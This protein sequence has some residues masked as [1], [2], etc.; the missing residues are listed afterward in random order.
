MNNT[1]N[2]SSINQ[3]LFQGALG[4]FEKRLRDAGIKEESIA[5]I[6]GRL[7][8]TTSEELVED[9]KTLL[10]ESEMTELEKMPDI[11]A[12]NKKIDSIL[13]DKK[14]ISL[15]KYQEEKLEKFVADFE[16]KSNSSQSPK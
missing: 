16:S 13:Q 6:C 7:I 15:E 12:R 10:S 9:L 3:L 2:I 5:F 8:R 1:I 14:G 4:R 11:E